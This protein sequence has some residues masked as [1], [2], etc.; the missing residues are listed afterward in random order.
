MVAKNANSVTGREGSEGCVI[1]VL[2]LVPINLGAMLA[3][4]VNLNTTRNGS[5]KGFACNAE[6]RRSWERCAGAAR[7][8]CDHT[9]ES[10]RAGKIRTVRERIGKNCAARYSSTM[11]TVAPVAGSIIHGFLPSATGTK[12]AP[13]T[14][15]AECINEVR[16][17]G[18]VSLVQLGT[19][20]LSSSDFRLI[21]SFNVG[22]AT[23]HERTTDTAVMPRTDSTSD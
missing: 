9:G 23:W 6:Q 7:S 22:I 12:T 20:G 21:W 13:P 11:G 5:Q 19:A 8:R 18:D 10:R 1:T 2:V 4:S 16:T 17:K 14:C 15:V 3:E